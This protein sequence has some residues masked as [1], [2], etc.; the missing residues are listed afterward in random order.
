MTDKTGYTANR[1]PSAPT[2]CVCTHIRIRHVGGFRCI[3]CECVTFVRDAILQ[4][5][6]PKP[7]WPK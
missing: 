2:Y 3:E 7:R 1:P 5:P 6:H 4:P